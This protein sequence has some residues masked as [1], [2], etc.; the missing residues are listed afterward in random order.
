MSKAKKS[1]ALPS[2]FDLP[3]APGSRLHRT[4]L[5]VCD[6]GRDGRD[7]A[8]SLHDPARRGICDRRRLYL[9]AGRRRA[10]GLQLPTR[11]L[12]PETRLVAAR[13]GRENVSQ[14]GV[15][16]AAL[17]KKPAVLKQSR[18]GRRYI[19]ALTY[20]DEKGS[21]AELAEHLRTWPIRTT[22]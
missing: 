3:L 22:N 16:L 21:A 1:S 19:D 5:L 6:A 15:L 4:L 9:G 13:K 20:L 2:V 14:A 7:A 17:E 18:I 10:A 12:R 8:A 11:D